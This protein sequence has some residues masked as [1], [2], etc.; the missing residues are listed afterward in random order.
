MRQ[1]NS[2]LPGT[3]LDC[4][5]AAFPPLWVDVKWYKEFGVTKESYITWL[6]NTLLQA[7]VDFFDSKLS[8]GK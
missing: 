3:E 5:I 8:T 4:M 2:L 1:L 7:C 6:S